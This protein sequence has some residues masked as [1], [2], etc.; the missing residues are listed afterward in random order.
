MEDAVGAR[1]VLDF[2][3]GA[4]ASAGRGRARG[5]WFRKDPAFDALIH[6]RFA[7][8]HAQALAADLDHWGGEPDSLL[9]L[10]VELDQFSRNMYRG[11]AKSFAGDARALAF[12]KRTV[13]RGWDLGLPAFKR[14]FVYMPYEHSEDLADQ[15]AC[16]RLMRSLGN[17]PVVAGVVE[18]ALKHREVIARFGRFPHRNAILGRVSTAAELAFLKQPNS[19]F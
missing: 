12:A 7:A 15:D 13:L 16:V 9:A 3:F 14:W 2:W 6:A 17:D 11:S 18:W 10:I 5:F 4:P 1:E 8:L 19:S